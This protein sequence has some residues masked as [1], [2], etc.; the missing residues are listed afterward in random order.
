MKILLVFFLCLHFTAKCIIAGPIDTTIKTVAILPFN[1]T[2]DTSHLLNGV[3]A[4]NL[5]RAAKF[6]RYRYQQYLYI[7]LI[8][9]PW[10]YNVTFQNIIETREIINRSG[11]TDSIEIKT[12][13]QL[14]SLLG[15]DAVLYGK[16]YMTKP[17]SQESANIINGITGLPLSASNKIDLELTIYDFKGTI[18]WKETQHVRGDVGQENMIEYAM[19]RISKTF[20]LKKK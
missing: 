7:W 17:H 18:T 20:P 9:K 8:K 1:V 5:L 10:K 2:I 13:A 4:E 12:K 19:K 14:C 16:I 15:V 3:N 6:S 11:I